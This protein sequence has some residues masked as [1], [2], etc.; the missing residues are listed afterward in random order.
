MKRRFKIY[1]N[2]EKKSNEICIYSRKKNVRT[3]EMGN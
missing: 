3:F 2:E 1:K